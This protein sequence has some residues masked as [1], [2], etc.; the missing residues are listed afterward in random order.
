MDDWED[1]TD[2]EVVD[3]V[4]EFLPTQDNNDHH[5]KDKHVK[6]VEEIK[7][8]YE[9]LENKMIKNAIV[10][11]VDS[12]KHSFVN[13]LGDDDAFDK[14]PTVLVIPTMNCQKQLQTV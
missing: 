10:S 12:R 9:L 11:D 5:D 3:D 4:I 8:Q 6:N 1:M 7:V 2:E 13:N 14:K